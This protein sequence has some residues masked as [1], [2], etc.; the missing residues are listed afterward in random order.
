MTFWKVLPTIGLSLLLLPVLFYSGRLLLRPLP[1]PKTQVLFQGITYDR[2]FH[3]SPRPHLIHTVTIDL[4]TPGLQV[5][6][7]P[8]QALADGTENE[9]RTTSQFAQEFN[10]QL[11]INANFFYPFE[12]K[13]PWH[14]YPRSG[15]RVSIL[16]QATSNGTTYSP[17]EYPWPTLCISSTNQATIIDHQAIHQGVTCPGDTQ[18]AIA[19]NQE[20]IDN[21]QPVIWNQAPK[22]NGRVAVA[23]D[24]MGQTLWIIVIDGKQPLYSEGVTIEELT[25]ILSEL[26]VY[27]AINLDGGGSTTLVMA[28][29]AGRTR[30]LN[31][32][33]HTRIPMRERPVANHLGFYGLQ[34]SQPK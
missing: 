22:P 6:A 20:L 11:A 28:K 15:D 23:T 31:A 1:T 29:F 32:P 13:S 25:D 5:L 19:G 34:P 8:G 21:G 2:Q 33:I 14:Y 4:T 16:G 7:T 30:V 18:Q 27:A 17:R 26:K 12:E 10:L 3:R 24:K 9:A